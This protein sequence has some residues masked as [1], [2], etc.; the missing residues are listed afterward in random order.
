M[1]LV[2]DKLLHI[3]LKTPNMTGTHACEYREKFSE[4]IL[5]EFEASP[6]NNTQGTEADMIDNTVWIKL[7]V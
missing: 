3:Y 2:C 4:L 7:T 5:W 1:V 6:Q